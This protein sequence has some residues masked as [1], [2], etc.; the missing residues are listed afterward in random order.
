MPL[1]GTKG[2][3]NYLIMRIMGTYLR[4]GIVGTYQ[5]KI[6]IVATYQKK[7]RNCGNF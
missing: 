7:N 4:F 5:K 3:K 6:G 2:I 1:E